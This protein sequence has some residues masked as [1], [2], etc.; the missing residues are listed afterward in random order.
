MRNNRSTCGLRYGGGGGYH[1]RVVCR[2]FHSAPELPIT[3]GWNT[4]AKHGQDSLRCGGRQCTPSAIVADST[5]S[6]QTC[7]LPHSTTAMPPTHPN[8]ARPLR[9][10]AAPGHASAAWLPARTPDA[11]TA[12]HPV[13]YPRSIGPT[14]DTA[15]RPC[16]QA[17]DQRSMPRPYC[18][19]Q[20]PLPCIPK[21]PVRLGHRVDSGPGAAI[22]PPVIDT[23][24][25][26]RVGMS[27]SS[28]HHQQDSRYPAQRPRQQPAVTAGMSAPFSA[29]G[30]VCN[31]NPVTPPSPVRR[32]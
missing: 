26:A 5:L 28:G 29:V 16:Y 25:G 15:T 24:R 12:R 7:H 8:P 18:I 17:D 11:S 23:R 6:P 14:F 19:P 4:G 32:P 3:P 20:R 13:R 27:D 2:R 10:A 30:P 31:A 1:R 22:I 21:K 9:P